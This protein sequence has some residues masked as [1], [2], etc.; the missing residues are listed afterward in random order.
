MP[1]VC[2][3][4]GRSVSQIIGTKELFTRYEWLMTASHRAAAAG[5]GGEH[6]TKKA[7]TVSV[8][9]LNYSTF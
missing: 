1:L 9:V 5:A 8:C 4:V 7:Y 3:V 2:A 6:H